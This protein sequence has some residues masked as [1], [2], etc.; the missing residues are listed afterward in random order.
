LGILYRHFLAWLLLGATML[1]AQAGVSGNALVVS[2][3]GPPSVSLTQYFDVLE[4]DSTALSIADVR[5]TDIAK[6]FRTDS[7]NIEGFNFSYNRSAFWLRLTLNNPGDHELERLLDVGYSRL[8]SVKL[9]LPASGDGYRSVE[10]GNAMPFASR[11]YK[12]RSFVFPVTLPPH[13]EQ[14]V[15]LR[16]QCDGPVVIPAKL[17]EPAA[18]HAFERNDYLTQSWYFGMAMAMILFNFL[19]FLVLRD[20]IYVLYVCFVTCVALAVAGQNG[21]VKEFIWTDA[22]LWSE[23]LPLVFYSMAAVAFLQFMRYMMA[24]RNL[25]PKCDVMIRIFM[26][27]HA[28]AIAGVFVAYQPLAKPILQFYLVTIALIMGTALYGALKGQRS[29]IIFVAIFSVM[30]IAATTNSLTGLGVL[31][32][33]FVTRNVLQ[34]GSASEMMLLALAQADRY[35]QFRR[36]KEEAQHEALV[37]QQRLVDNLKTSER[38]LEERVEERTVALSASNDRLETTLSDLRMVHS[39]QGRFIAMLSHELKTPLAVIDSAAQALERIDQSNDPNVAR[40]H[41]RIRRSVTRIDRLVEQFLTKDRIDSDGMAVRPGWIDVEDVLHQL[42]EASA[43]AERLQLTVSALPPLWGDG[44]LLHVAV[45]NLVD[46]ALKYAPDHTVIRLSAA[47]R[48][49]QGKPGIGIVV[50]DEGPGLPDELQ[51]RIFTRYSRGSNVGQVSGAGLGLYL[52]KRIAELH[53]GGVSYQSVNG[54]AAFLLWLPE[55]LASDAT[56]DSGALVGAA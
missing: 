44:A 50:A 19:L 23:V 51:A 32:T 17:W 46:N 3:A 45:S 42:A 10:T 35:I 11:P 34:I 4:D 21:L 36:Q 40:R 28:L 2:P 24:T 6:N 16:I 1:G 15:F 13:S 9:Y 41:D 8:T 22:P 52:V 53:G 55:P 48:A 56:G 49:E 5:R 26:T 38:I 7:P 27:I 47:T 33:T 29:A 43:E 12:N 39:E 37:S 18:F 20:V 14:V 31:P 54:T 25:L 30:F